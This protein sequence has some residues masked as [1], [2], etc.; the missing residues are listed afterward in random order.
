M[1][2]PNPSGG[3]AVPVTL[4]AVASHMRRRAMRAEEEA[5][6]LAITVRDLNA[7][8][9]AAERRIAELEKHDVKDGEWSSDVAIHDRNRTNG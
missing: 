6:L 3:E 5:L 9:T 7:S 4:D 8:L 1:N 2:Q